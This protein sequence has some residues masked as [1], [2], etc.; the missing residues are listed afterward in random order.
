MEDTT[1]SEDKIGALEKLER[2]IK[3]HRQFVGNV[4]GQEYQNE[5]NLD[6]INVKN[7]AKYLLKEGTREEKRELLSDIKSRISI[8]NEEIILKK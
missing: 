8:K 7:Y 1:V 4:L 5:A 2:E 3:R 6:G